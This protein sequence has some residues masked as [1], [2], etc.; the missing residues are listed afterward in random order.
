MKYEK[1]LQAF[2]DNQIVGMMEVDVK[3]RYLQ[4]NNHWSRMIGYSAEEIMS[5]DFQSITHPDDLPR[6]LLLDKELEDGKRNSYRIDKRYI[7]KDGSLFWGDLSVTGLYN[8][9]NTLTGM[10]GLVIDITEKK[11]S[12]EK[13]KKTEELQ[14][15]LLEASPDII[16]FKDGE[17]RWLLAN[18]TDLKLFQL[19]G[20]DYQGKTDVELAPYSPFYSDA[21]INCKK[22]DEL[23]WKTRGISIVDEVIPTP[24]GKERVFEVIKYP[25]FHPDGSREALVVL[26]RDI[27]LRK[28]T[29]DSL[30]ESETRFRNLLDQLEHIPIQ[31]YD[32]ERRVIY[33]NTASTDVYGYTREEAF[34]Q[35][36]E[37]LIIPA[38]MRDNVI[39]AIQLWL[40]EDRLVPSGEVTL[41]N[42]D[43]DAVSVYSSHILHTTTSGE[44]EIFCVDIDLQ[45]LH[46]TETQLH[47][48][49][50][51]IE[52][53]GEII[54][55]TD[56]KGA[57]EYV[58]PAFTTVTGYT[59]D[60]IIG[61]NPRI[62]NSG[63][64]S[65]SVY[66][67]LWKSITQ[68]KTWKGRLINKKKDG[69]YFTED[70]MISPIFNSA[71]TIV[72]FVAAKRDITEQLLTEEK[73][74]HAQKMEAIGQLAGGVAHDFNNMLAI[75]LGQVE[76][77]LMK[78]APDDPLEKR[79]QEIRIAANRSSNLTQQ[80]LGFARK[81]SRQS[82]V[83]N[84]SDTVATMLIMLKRLIGE[85]LEL[86]WTAEAELPLVDIDPG[87]FDQILTNLIINARDAI[88]TIGVIS[89][90][91]RHVLLDETF[92][93]DHP[94]SRMGEFILLEVSD[95]GCGMDQETIDKIFNPFFTTKGIGKGTGLGLSMVFGLVK[96]NNGY[97][98]VNSTPEQG[99][100]FSLYFP[101]VRVEEE[102]KVQSEG[103]VLVKGTETILVVEDENPLLDTTLAMLTEAGYRVLSAQ[104][105][106]AAIQLAEKH[107]KPIHLLL[108]DIVMPKMN[109]VELSEHL[110]GIKPEIKVLFMSGYPK[111]HFSQLKQRNLTAQLLKKP[112]T[113]HTLAK[114]VREILDAS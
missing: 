53:V 5:K 3:G 25:L 96:Q 63:E 65:D 59:L 38:H 101:Q 28:R 40:S 102:M 13:L 42:K 87:H 77:A 39:E 16:C 93:R 106:F 34:G 47:Q 18:K 60:E 49:A 79:L 91:T 1:S 74:Q 109:G 89:V 33:W 2:F 56:T 9:R 86:R 12:E 69:N 111:G 85:H 103:K 68:G 70:A 62:L 26:G 110:L 81:Q 41:C 71:G 51:A 107:K 114:K 94:G 36:L 32:A 11:E 57:I 88:D 15:T 48:L 6:Q 95:S 37:D 105:P 58:N 61:Q 83:L 66:S 45:Q 20:I 23:A 104:G 27:T 8:K 75:I 73:Y 100:T 4:V 29:E 19:E 78:I 30:R 67:E 10:V 44:K 52:Q 80:L 46:K 24:D 43:G 90:K 35:K 21:F 31:G 98:A 76:I 7:R 92:C 54:I 108:T 84:L 112:F 22:T 99:S 82:Q 64:Q 113:T 55:I 72:N 17:G 14:R 50:T 97:I